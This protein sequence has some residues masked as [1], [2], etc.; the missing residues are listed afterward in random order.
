MIPRSN[1]KYREV[2]FDAL[3]ASGYSDLEI[4]G[5]SRKRKE[6]DKRAAIACVMRDNF[7]NYYQIGEMI[8][9]KYPVIC[10]SYLPLRMYVS[11][12][13]DRIKNNMENNKK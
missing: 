2:Y 8:N 5:D 10:K 3:R 7:C 1:P 12:E 4:K 13:I 11:V 9:R 6:V